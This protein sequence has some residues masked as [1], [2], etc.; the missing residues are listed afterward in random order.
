MISSTLRAAVLL[1]ALGNIHQVQGQ[2]R[3]LDSLLTLLEKHPA[4]D[5]ARAKLLVQT[6]RTYYWIDPWKG[7]KVADE[8]VNVARRTGDPSL[9][10]MAITRKVGA[11]QCTGKF[12]DL[13]PL[14]AEAVVL[15]SKYGP[16]NELAYARW[17]VFMDDTQNGLDSTISA[18]R[19]DSLLTLFRVV[20]DPVGE[21]W[22]LIMIA[23]K[24]NGVDQARSDSL[25]RRALE[26]TDRPGLRSE[27]AANSLRPALLA[28]TRGDLPLATVLYEKAI[29][30]LEKEG[31]SHYVAA[32]T[33]TLGEWYRYWGDF[34]QAIKY[35][36][37]GLQ[38]YEQMDRQLDVSQSENNIGC[39]YREMGDLEQAV[40]HFERAYGI[41]LGLNSPNEILAGLNDLGLVDLAR[42]QPQA[43]LA[44]FNAAWPLCPQVEPIRGMIMVV[45]RR[46]E[47]QRNIGLA[48]AALGDMNGAIAALETSEHED[49]ISQ[50]RSE[51]AITRIA[52][53]G[54]LLQVVR[55]QY[56]RAVSLYHQA[57]DSAKANGWVNQQRDAL[58]GLS[59]TH[60]QMG[61]HEQA[62][63]YLKEH[64][65][66][67]EAQL[68]AQKTQLISTMQLVYDTEKKEQ[69]IDLLGKEKEVQ[70][71]EIIQQ[72]LVRKGLIG[73]V[74]LVALLAGALLL[75]FR[76]SRRNEAV[77][78]VKNTAI[79]DAQEQLMRSERQREASEVR[80]RIA[81]DVHD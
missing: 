43:A 37:A 34:V 32:A 56:E 49:T 15:L 67:K 27:Y 45:F 16:R 4:Q 53:A 48:K 38:A 13:G 80:T 59:N 77:L 42:N 58:L 68:D 28:H 74:A 35:H 36:T 51:V 11:H 20:G 78:Q 61:D 57:A 47:C 65:A 12:N 10:G 31:C 29:G 25:I 81:R 24:W 6:A 23:L 33:S 21:S 50:L 8:A 75:L 2:R 79:I 72:K 40:P 52:L 5:A 44:K 64:M 46:M 60:A 3:Q 70:V 22:A 73:G 55:P 1:V 7:E 18:Q 62:L 14:I 30:P 69:R 54:V 63:H 41:A 19:C 9:L 66:V 71:Q 39:I 76:N 17:C 26:L